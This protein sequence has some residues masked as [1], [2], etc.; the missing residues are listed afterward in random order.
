MTR[1]AAIARSRRE[2]GALVK[3]TAV[4]ATLAAVPLGW[5]AW[6]AFVIDHEVP[7][8][9]ALNAER[10][11]MRD[12]FAGGL[13]WYQDRRGSGRPVVL[14]HSINAAASAYEMRPTF[15]GLRGRR[16]VYALELPGFGFS[17]RAPRAYTPALYAAAIVGFLE[18]LGV[19]GGVHLVALSLSSE[20]AALAAL[21]HPALVRSL[22]LISPS[23]F[24]AP[25]RLQTL[26]RAQRN[27]VTARVH[28][29]LEGRPW[30]QATYD[31]LVSRPSI[32][33]FLGQAF[34]GP[35]ASALA[36]YCFAT[37]HRP[38]ARHAPFAFLSGGLF[39]PDIL[40]RAYERLALPALVLYDRSA[41]VTYD[42]LPELL[43][44]HANWR[45]ERVGPAKDML[46]YERPADALR[47]METLWR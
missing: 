46:H 42:R 45:A 44:G 27:G 4:V 20:F 32:A 19:E 12:P 11:E 25:E 33:Y 26:Q 21:E 47:A 6:S 40:A 7:L 5:M 8:P 13:S 23:G 14:V 2:H 9:P 28:D 17:E 36:E 31:A 18:R 10:R 35:F 38:G 39:T 37:T 43:D 41:N 24:S 34:D 22:T 1:R 16:P 15:E 30:S 3:A 29:A